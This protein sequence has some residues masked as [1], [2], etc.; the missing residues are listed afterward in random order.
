MAGR[1]NSSSA[2]G[3]GII[4]KKNIS[5]FPIRALGMLTVTYYIG[6]LESYGRPENVRYYV[7]CG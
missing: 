5:A 1:R 3:L 6:E 7:A 4:Y 2:G